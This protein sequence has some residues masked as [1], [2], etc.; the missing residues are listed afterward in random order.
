MPT[1]LA[2]DD[3][4]LKQALRLEASDQKSNGNSSVAGV[5]PAQA[6]TSRDR[7]VRKIDFDPSFH[8]KKYRK[9]RGRSH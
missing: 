9:R 8:Y 5:H 2:L 6:T 7:P 1:N 3:N 4:L